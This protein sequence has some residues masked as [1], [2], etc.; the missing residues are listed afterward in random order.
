M[1]FVK[2]FKKVNAKKQID[3]LAKKYKNKK[4][5]VYGA[6][7]MSR[8]L[9]ENYDLSKLNIVAICDIK[10]NEKKEDYFSY[11]TISQEEL[12]TFDCEVILI[13]V[14]RY[15]SIEKDLKYKILFDTKNENT[16]I[17]KFIKL[18]FS[19]LLKEILF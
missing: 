13:L 7:I 9:F 3:N 14:Q 6:G 15:L 16:K 17:E 11:K 2:Y 1:D 19:V 8:T 18:P 10:Y 4:I 5:V 12:K